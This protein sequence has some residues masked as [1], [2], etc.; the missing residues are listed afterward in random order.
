M[1][2]IKD[3]PVTVRHVLNHFDGKVGLGIVPILDDDNCL[4]GAIDVDCHGDH[5]P[6]IDIIALSK[7]IEENQLPL[8][9]CR[10][11]SGGAHLY[12]FLQQPTLAT[13]VRDMLAHWSR[14]L[15]YEG[16][17][18]F[19]K[20]VSLKGPEDQRPLGNW[21]NLP[22]FKSEDT[23]RY[24]VKFGSPVSLNTFIKTAEANRVDLDEV[25]RLAVAD[26]AEAPPCVQQI[27]KGYAK[28]GVRNEALYA[29][30]VYLKKRDGEGFEVEGAKLAKEIFNPPLK[31]QEVGRTLAQI[32]NNNYSYKCGQSP[33]QDFC[34]RP[35]CYTR[36]YGIEAR[37]REGKAITEMFANLRRYESDPVIWE[38][39]VE[40]RS[41]R[42]TTEHLMNAS[43]FR[44]AAMEKA[45]ILLNPMK[46]DEWNGILVNLRESMQTFAVPDDASNAGRIRR[47][48]LE[49]VRHCDLTQPGNP[50]D[51]L[52]GNPVVMQIGGKMCVA[53]RGSDFVEYLKHHRVEDS[54]S[55]EVYMAVERMGVQ[56]TKVK[57]SGKQEE[58]WYLEIDSEV[59]D[60]EIEVPD[61]AP[62]Y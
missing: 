34:N 17:E 3:E 37:D 56:H 28:Q 15:G 52:V 36:R 45:A 50:N 26:H 1:W 38:V 24:L 41:V 35:V 32:A 30:G 39:D 47:K 42:M 49:F 48:L 16:S 27:I 2:T 25:N 58:V 60:V 19:P 46:Q 4:W 55:N 11:K 43:R 20:Q 40:G 22:Y 44:I 13:K 6:E 59:Q 51:L 7:K 62:E 57:V 54:R 14:A 31:P 9:P 8:I 29:V 10:S 61:Y 23:D 5:T 18:I 33:C 21:I 53:F 12:L